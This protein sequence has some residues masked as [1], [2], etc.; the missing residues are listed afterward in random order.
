[1]QPPTVLPADVSLT[2][3]TSTGTTKATVQ[4][5]V[6]TAIGSYINS[7]PIGACLPLTKLA[8]IAYSAS[9]GGGQCQRS[10]DERRREHPVPERVTISIWTREPVI[11]RGEGGA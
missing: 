9:P 8:Q 11:T 5:L 2:I 6:G 4:A 10:A 3:T 1:M 7:L